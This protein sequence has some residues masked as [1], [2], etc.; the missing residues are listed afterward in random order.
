MDDSIFPARI[1][2]TILT[3][4]LG[5]GK[6]T[7]LNAIISQ[8]EGKKIAIIENEFGEIS[9]DSELVIAQN[10]G[11]FELSNGCI[12]CSLSGEL[13]ETLDKI[14]ENRSIQHLIIETTGIADPGP[15]A[16]SFISDFKIQSQF[17][18]DAIVCLVDSRFIETQLENQY[19]ASKQIAMADIILL[20]K[21]DQV[22]DYQRDTIK[23]IVSKIN[24]QATVY[25]SAFGKVDGINLLEINGFGAESVLM[26]KF[27]V[28]SSIA[29][30]KKF[31][32]N[33][34]VEIST[35]LVSNQPKYVHKSG[36]S[37]VSFVFPEPL[38]VLKLD[39]WLNVMLNW[40]TGLF[41]RGKGILY[42][43]NFDKKVVFQSV[44]NQFVTESGG[45]WGNE[46]K[47]TKIVFIGKYLDKVLLE[48][49]LKSCIVNDIDASSEDFFKAIMD[50]QDKLYDKM[51]S[52][53]A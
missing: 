18:L 20:N 16:L 52:A 47:M 46:P 2:V 35:S 19:E 32:V 21:M 9:I 48:A 15:I 8:N 1:P 38:D 45:E 42:V 30:T 34:E 6:T 10:E 40:G 29:K 14:R 43:E 12:C 23:N 26:T 33:K 3:G 4:F 25:E 11:I 28:D 41:Y 7:L 13:S 17:R 27:E 39:A 22:D 37:S 5:S 44:L 24:S 53:I 51:K 31:S 50:M 36:V 49:G